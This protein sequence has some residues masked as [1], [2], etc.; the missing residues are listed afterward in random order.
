MKVKGQEMVARVWPILT[1]AIEEGV[2]AGWYRAHK[3]E[4]K[5]GEEKIKTDIEEAVMN[6]MCE[7]FEMPGEKE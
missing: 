6:S 1:R 2:A 5:P 7:Y 3:H 4:D